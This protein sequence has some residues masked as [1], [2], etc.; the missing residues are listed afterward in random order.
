MD[1]TV[2]INKVKD[3]ITD[4]Y[5]EH[6]TLI[7]D[8]TIMIDEINL[9]TNLYD[10]EDYNLIKYIKDKIETIFGVS[11]YIINIDKGTTFKH[12]YDFIVD[13]TNECNVK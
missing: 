10:I 6:W 13:Y 5:I 7:K 8:N 12:I 4:Y 9:N 2:F 11:L 1:T 3:I